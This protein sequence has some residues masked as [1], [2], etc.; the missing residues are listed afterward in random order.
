MNWAGFKTEVRKHLLGF[1][2]MQGV[3]TYIDTLIL[4]AVQ[5]LQRDVPEYQVG[6]TDV[7]DLGDVTLD[8]F[9]CIGTKPAGKINDIRWVEVD[10]S[11]EIIPDQYVSAEYV[12]WTEV[13]AMR[14]GAYEMRPVVSFD[15]RG[16]T[17]AFSPTLTATTRLV[18]EWDGIKSSFGDSDTVPFDEKAAQCVADYVLS[19][20]TARVDHDLA[21]AQMHQGRF[22]SGKRTLRSDFIRG[23]IV[24]PPSRSISTVADVTYP[25]P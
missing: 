18:I 6:H 22:L 3:Q 12:P 13:P 24:G 1:A 16:A 9:A 25:T 11:N 5:E 14:A 8:G 19:S 4:L 7:L 20:L 23:R 2:R 21:T 17:F 10:G 15:S